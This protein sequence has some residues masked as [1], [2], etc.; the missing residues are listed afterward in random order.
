MENYRTIQGNNQMNITGYSQQNNILG[1]TISNQKP[2]MINNPFFN[3]MLA[4]N[5]NNNIN[6]NNMNINSM[7][8]INNMNMINQNNMNINQNQ[9]QNKS[10]SYLNHKNM[11][12]NGIFP[13]TMANNTIKLNPYDN[14]SKQGNNIISYSQKLKEQKGDIE[15]R[16]NNNFNNNNNNLNINIINTK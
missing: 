12:Y 1:K 3:E 11:K 14:S 7:N 6:L 13:N 16:M 4:N 5:I 2:N 8:N 9:N 15:E 10:L